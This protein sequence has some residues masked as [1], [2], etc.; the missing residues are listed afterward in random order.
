M[1]RVS[2]QI[3]QHLDPILH[4]A[5]RDAFRRLGRNI[6]EMLEGALHALPEG[7][8]VFRDQ[9]VREGLD[10]CAVDTF[11]AFGHKMRDGMIA[12][13]R[14]D[15]P[16][17]QACTRRGADLPRPSA[18]R[19]ELDRG[20]ERHREQREGHGVVG[21]TRFLVFDIGGKLREARVDVVPGAAL[22]PA[23]HAHRR[24]VGIPGVELECAGQRCLRLVEL[25][26][27]D[28]QRA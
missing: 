2:V 16:H 6:G 15:E 5:P 28:A 1:R 9:A 7:A 18:R 11:A 25:A 23:V 22:Q 4:Y 19:R 21:R 17:A 20:P 27:D 3:D 26:L 14:R 8:R 24:R 12:E 10:A 13:V